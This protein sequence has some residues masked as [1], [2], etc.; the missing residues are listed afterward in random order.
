[1]SSGPDGPSD[2][3]PT[4]CASLDRLLGG[5]FEFGAL[6]QVFGEGGSGKTS[7]ALQL[8]VATARAGKKA[9]YIDTEGLSAERF[10]QISGPEVKA[11]SGRVIVFEPRSFLEQS[12]VLEDVE[13]IAR[14]GVG[15]VVW[16]S[17]TFYYRLELGGDEQ[18]LK[19]ELGRQM[20][21]LLRIARERNLVALV[22]NQIYTDID[23]DAIRPL[24][25][26]IVEHLCKTILQL[27]K[28]G[29]AGRRRAVLKKHRSLAEGTSCEVRLTDRGLEDV[30]DE[31]AVE[32]RNR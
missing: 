3:L 23:H 14:E 25:G 26:S 15:L 2:R 5:G 8:A 29:K 32:I 20:A 7:L 21:A 28:T 30:P 31:V 24:G 11:V 27:E 17:A 6:S 18:A 22:T 13:R 4:G 12:S 19:R 9:V 1:M 10:R 16:D